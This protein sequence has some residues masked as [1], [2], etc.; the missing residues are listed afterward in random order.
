[1]GIFNFLQ[2]KKPRRE[3]GGLP[4]QYARFRD[5]LAP[6]QMIPAPWADGFVSLVVRETD[7]GIA[8]IGR[9]PVIYTV[10]GTIK[11]GE[12][13]IVCL[14]LRIS[15]GHRC[16]YETIFDLMRP[17]CVSDLK[18][19][20]KQDQLSVVVVGESTWTCVEAP[21]SPFLS[22]NIGAHTDVALSDGRRWANDEFMAGVEAMRSL[23][24]DTAGLWD[25]FERE[26][27]MIEIRS[28]G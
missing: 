5:I 3:N 2:K 26:G 27:Q 9:D 6:G 7:S 1:M 19:L 24:R 14:L 22:A 23:S 10:P 4:E 8:H 17:E 13:R 15:E 16:T 25:I 11:Y 20:S 21:M 18:A 28:A 12:A